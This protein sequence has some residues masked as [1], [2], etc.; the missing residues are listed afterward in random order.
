LTLRLALRPKTNVDGSLTLL[1]ES[2]FEKDGALKPVTLTFSLTSKTRRFPPGSQFN[3]ILDDGPLRFTENGSKALLGPV[4]LQRGNVHQRA[5]IKLDSLA[6][7]VIA[8]S[9]KVEGRIGTIEFQLTPAQLRLLLEFTKQ[10]AK[11][12]AELK[13]DEERF[14]DEL[15]KAEDKFN[16]ELEKRKDESS[17]M[18]NL[19]RLTRAEQRAEGVEAELVDVKS[20][21]DDLRSRLKQIEDELRPEKLKNYYPKDERD[22]RRGHLVH[23]QDRIKAQLSILSDSEARLKG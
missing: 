9:K 20:K 15:K 3:A 17:R 7:L 16:D 5:Y 1:L 8:I 18:L 11:R 22:E 2:W 10:T 14:N 12:Q 13:R 21:E 6:L 19:E 4:A 23:E